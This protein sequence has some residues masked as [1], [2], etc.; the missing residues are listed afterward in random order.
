METF[1]NFAIKTLLSFALFLVVWLGIR[2]LSGRLKENSGAVNFRNGAILSLAAFGLV[3]LTILAQ[4]NF[5]FEEIAG[6]REFTFSKCVRCSEGK[7][8]TE[9]NWLTGIAIKNDKLF[10]KGILSGEKFENEGFDLSSG[11]CQKSSTSRFGFQCFGS[12]EEKGGEYIGDKSNLTSMYFDGKTTF[13]WL[14]ETRTRVTSRYGS[15][16]YTHTTETTCQVE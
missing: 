13:R 16:E 7:C 5:R 15:R 1:I 4:H 11:R 14:S 12:S 3:I 9:L 2:A 10:V 8:A 6:K